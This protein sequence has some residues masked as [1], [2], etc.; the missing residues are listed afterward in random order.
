MIAQ[1]MQHTPGWV[2]VLL[3]ALICLGYLQSRTRIVPKARLL[4]LP[5]AMLGL[6]LYSLIATFGAVR[7]GLLGRPGRLAVAGAPLLFF[8]CLRIA[9]Q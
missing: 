3:L 1:T 6:S 9:L 5:A 7:L 8:E 4:A 2:W